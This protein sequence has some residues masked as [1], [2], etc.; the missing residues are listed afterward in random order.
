MI[1]FAPVSQALL[2]IFTFQ[3]QFP[4]AVLGRLN[5]IS[6]DRNLP[7]SEAF[8]KA[9]AEHADPSEQQHY[10]VQFPGAVLGRFQSS[11]LDPTSPPLD[12]REIAPSQVLA[13]QEAGPFNPSQQHDSVQD[14]LA[15]RLR[16]YRLSLDLNSS[17]LDDRE[18]ESRISQMLS[19]HQAVPFHPSDQQPYA[20]LPTVNPST[21][22]PSR[23]AEFSTSNLPPGAA[24][25]N[26]L[27]STAGSSRVSI[28]TTNHN[29]NV[30]EQSRTPSTLNVATTSDMPPVSEPRPGTGKQRGRPPRPSKWKGQTSG[31]GKGLASDPV[32]GHVPL[33]SK[34]PTQTEYSA[35]F[36]M[37]V[38]RYDL[39][40]F[41]FQKESKY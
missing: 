14:P 21:D 9:Q 20:E 26:L 1:L 16:F 30:E 19:K 39:F 29:Q 13:N 32:N 33:S 2:L 15:E 12:D 27:A 25:D 6:L 31:L 36:V 35:P 11:P 24:Q 40:K 7:F 17:P 3:F 28:A 10:P 34:Q 37:S 8:T 38:N 18:I 22:V 5:R 4:W 41:D 23:T